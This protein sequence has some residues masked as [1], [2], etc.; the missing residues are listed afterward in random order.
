MTD[1]VLRLGAL[2]VAA[3]DD[4]ALAALADAVAAEQHARAL[5]RADLDALVAEGFARGFDRHGLAADPF[6]IGGVLVCPG[7]KVDR[8]A[9]G[10]DCTF[11]SVNGRWAW[12]HDGVLRDEIRHPAGGRPQMR[13]VTLVVVAAGTPVD[14]VRSRL[15]AGGHRL[16]AARSFRT[17]GTGLALVDT[18]WVAT[19][20][21]R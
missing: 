18:R 4:A 5:A 13:S 7:A 21:H 12:E 15:R 1:A 8:S 16:V 20:P 19:T 11:V 9:T 3:L 10:H 2:D 6:V 17:T 14:W